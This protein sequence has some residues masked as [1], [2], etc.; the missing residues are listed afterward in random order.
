[1]IGYT[2]LYRYCRKGEE[3]RIEN[4]EEAKNDPNEL[5]VI[6]HRLELTLN[7]EF[8][9]TQ[10]ELKR[11]GMF[12]HRPYYEL[13]F[14]RKGE[15]S[16]LHNKSKSEIT[17]NKHRNSAKGHKVSEETREKLR[18]SRLGKSPWNKGKK[19]DYSTSHPHTE[20][21]KKDFSIRFKGRFKG[22]TWKYIDGKRVWLNNGK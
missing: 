19:L 4:Y 1:M 6:H 7:G 22:M 21:L 13:I 2:R 11:L 16:V 20:E 14:L 17:L 9:H 18:N 3:T 5:W 10:D 8:A 15:H 12:Y